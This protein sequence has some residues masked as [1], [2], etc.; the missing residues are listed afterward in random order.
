[1]WA[2]WPK[3][4]ECFPLMAAWGF[5]YKTVLLVWTKTNK[6]GK[7]KISVGH[8]TRS[9][10]EFLLVATKG[11]PLTKV[12]D[13]KKMSFVSQIL[14]TKEFA[15]PS[16]T[17]VIRTEVE[18]HSKKPDAVREML[19]DFTPNSQRVEL[20]CRESHE[21]WWSWGDEVGNAKQTSLQTLFS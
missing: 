15:S 1:M 2:T 20:F 10:S 14:E 19:E 3:I 5:T 9:N 18:F 13:K 12:L 11:K 6:N 7:I 4:E 16:G 21:G 8:Y 17:P